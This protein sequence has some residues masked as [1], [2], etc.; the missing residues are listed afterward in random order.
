MSTNNGYSEDV[1]SPINKKNF[2]NNTYLQN[3]MKT[4]NY[5]N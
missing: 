1:N 5:I 2:Y 4:G 3:K